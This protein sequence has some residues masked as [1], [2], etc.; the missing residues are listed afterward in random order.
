MKKSM[1]L[2]AVIAAV[3][4]GSISVNAAEGCCPSCGKGK[5]DAAQTAT[6]AKCGE[7]KGSDKCCKADAVKCDK[8]GLDKGSPGCKAKC[9]A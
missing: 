4:V 8:C 5:K 3:V 6:C 2:L 7:L 9:G 1:W